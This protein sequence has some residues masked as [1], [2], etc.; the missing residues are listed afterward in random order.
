MGTNNQIN[1]LFATEADQ[2]RKFAQETSVLP[3][4]GESQEALR[5]SLTSE[6]WFILSG[7]KG[8]GKTSYLLFGMK[9]LP[10]KFLAVYAPF[11]TIDSKFVIKNKVDEN[12]FLCKHFYG[13][14]ISGL[15]KTIKET[16][17]KKEKEAQVFLEKMID[18]LIPVEIEQTRTVNSKKG[19]WAR[20]GIKREAIGAGASYGRSIDAQIIERRKFS[21]RPHYEEFREYL[22]ELIKFLGFEA[23][24]FYIDEVNEI[25]LDPSEVSCLFDHIYN[26]YKTKKESVCFKIAITDT[27]EEAVPDSIISGG[28]FEFKNLKSFL[29][30]PKQYEGFIHEILQERTK[31]LGIKSTIDEIFTDSALHILVMAS[32]GNPRDFFLRAREACSASGDKIN[33]GIALDTV[34]KIGGERE[35]RILDKGGIYRKTYEKLV[36]SLKERSKAKEGNSS[37]PTGVSYFMI[38]EADKLPPEIRD[39]LSL[40]ETEKIIYSTGSYRA[41]RRK[42]QKSEVLVLSYPI[43]LIKSIRFHD[44]VKAMEQTGHTEN[45]VISE[46]RATIR[47]G[48]V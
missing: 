15:D 25:R 34:K 14:L 17:P 43:C 20:I 5:S 46:H 47:L 3:K 36:E 41:L 2:N 23:V 9:D 35:K 32:M 40:L 22:I 37:S 39:A 29:Q 26:A 28:Y 4:A 1:Q 38:A 6:H 10:R 13:G 30:F 33:Q 7:D 11:E 8:S 12:E 16:L 48:E 21:P 24:V 19:F 31:L 45:Q 27:V 44:V 18:S 42:G